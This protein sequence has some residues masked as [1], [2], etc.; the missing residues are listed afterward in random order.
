MALGAVLERVGREIR[1]LPAGDAVRTELE[2][3][4]NR[5]FATLMQ[6]RWKL[7]EQ[8]GK[9]IPTPFQNVLIFWLAIVF[10]SLGLISPRNTLALTMIVL[11]AV[12]I[13]A[14]IFA[15]L[16]MSGPFDGL[17]TVSSDPMRDAL[18][19]LGG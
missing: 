6:D 17:I 5:H 3:A 19:H 9:T 8:A 13:A 11:G 18:A 15:I 2:A 16:E 7:V 1:R 4:A 10:L 14:V 12:A